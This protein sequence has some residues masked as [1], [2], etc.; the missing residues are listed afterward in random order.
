MR[1]LNFLNN[2][3]MK[4]M[5]LAT[6]LALGFGLV[7]ILTSVVAFMAYNG[8]NNVARNV[9]IADDANRLVKYML[10]TRREEKN[11]VIHGFTIPEGDK[12]NAA[13][14]LGDVAADFQP[15]IE[16]TKAKL[17]D[18]QNITAWAAVGSA[19]QNIIS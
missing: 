2:I 11:F 1:S 4:N 5:G 16:D 10:D 9:D 12:Q 15:Q 8:L 17:R 7:L 14:E 6:K 18:Q 3:S 13:E 19:Y